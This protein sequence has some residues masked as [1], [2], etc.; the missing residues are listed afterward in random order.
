MLNATAQQKEA[1]AMKFRIFMMVKAHCKFAA[2]RL[3]RS[4]IRYFNRRFV[5]TLAAYSGTRNSGL[6]AKCRDFWGVVPVLT[7]W[8]CC[9]EYAL[10]RQD[11][12]DLSEDH[13]VRRGHAPGRVN[14]ILF[15][16]S[17]NSKPCY[18]RIRLPQV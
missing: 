6:R 3:R 9:L 18:Y 14:G 16:R 10:L 13:G 8:N 2:R 15:S 17:F 7:H 5:E 12:P 1:F 11:T 4:D